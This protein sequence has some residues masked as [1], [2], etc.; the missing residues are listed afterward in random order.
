MQH[1]QNGVHLGSEDIS[2]SCPC[3]RESVFLKVIHMQVYVTYYRECTPQE[4]SF[5]ISFNNM[6]GCLL[7]IRH[8]LASLL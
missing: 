1:G 4:T 7:L 8:A 3:C 6:Q 2:A 5:I